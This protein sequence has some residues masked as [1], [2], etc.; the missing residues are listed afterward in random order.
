[1]MQAALRGTK[2]VR[3]F[4]G[5][6]SEDSYSGDMPH[7]IQH[8]R[9][10]EDAGVANPALPGIFVQTHEMS[11]ATAR[12]ASDPNDEVRALLFNVRAVLKMDVAFVSSFVDGRRVFREVSGESEHV[13]P[14]NSDPLEDTYC[15]RVVDGRIDA[16][17][18]DTS[19]DSEACQLEVTERLHIGAYLS[20]PVVLSNGRVYG[21]VCCISHQP[22][23]D[24]G[25]RERDA[26]ETVA[27]LV[28]TQMEKESAG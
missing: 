15:Q 8:E 18:P 1:M 13:K 19:L 6:D 10:T 12:E 28:S 21:T 16:V 5:I 27:R 26:L 22:R 25:M 11:V 2:N 4:L 3:F 17:I 9:F 20:V 24:L 23:A 7:S 14:G